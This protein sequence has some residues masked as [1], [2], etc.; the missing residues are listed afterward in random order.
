MWLYQEGWA[1]YNHLE[2]KISQIW[3]PGLFL[4]QESKSMSEPNRVS[5]FYFVQP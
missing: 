4:R 2:L 1:E 5:D 3:V